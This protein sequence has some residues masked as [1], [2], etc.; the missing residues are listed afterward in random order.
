ETEAAATAVLAGAGIE[1]GT[2][3]IPRAGRTTAGGTTTARVPPRYGGYYDYE[4]ERPRRPV[5][6][7]LLAL[8]LLAAAGYAGYFVYTKVEHQL[9]SSSIRVDNYK[10][11]VES[12]A[13]TK[14]RRSGL[15]PR[16]DREYNANVAVGVVFGQ[17]PSPGA[18][19]DK[20]GTVLIVVSRGKTKVEVPNVK[21]EQVTD[22]VAAL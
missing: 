1:E 11:I 2:R 16:I 9:S 14:I 7:W 8:L 10:G 19:L 6:P 21:G 20:G 12:L 5:W 18:S 15:K 4:G 13:V 3:V 17:D 22:A